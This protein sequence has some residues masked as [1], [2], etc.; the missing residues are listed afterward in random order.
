M[1]QLRIAGER[2]NQV[3]IVNVTAVA[4]I[5]FSLLGT[6]PLFYQLDEYRYNI[7]VRDPA[8]VLEVLFYSTVNIVFFLLGVIFIRKVVGLEDNKFSSSDIKPLSGFQYK[9]LYVVFIFCV[10]VLFKYLSQVDKIA[11]FVALTDVDSSIK[12]ARSDMGNS[13]S[14]KYH[15]YKLVMHDF[16]SLLTYC[17]FAL[18][19]MRKT[20]KS[21]LFFIITFIYSVFVDIMATEKAPLAWLLVGLFMV[22]FLVRRDGFVPFRKLISF[23]LLLVV[24]LMFSYIYFMGVRDFGSAIWSVFSRTFSGSIFPAYFYLEFF[25]EHQDYLFGKTFPN[26]GGLMPYEPYRY[27]I[28]VMNWLFPKLADSGVVG[29][30]PT[31]FWGEAYAN[32]GPIG[33]PIVAF[34]I[35][36]F[37]ALVSCLVSRLE[38]NPV[39]IGFLVWLILIFKSLST[40][41]FS[42]Y[43]Y[44]IY[45]VFVSVLVLFIYSM[46]G[47]INI[48]KK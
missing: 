36:C 43:L 30:A 32:F 39:S 16:G 41:G 4:L 9:S 37:V 46:R 35:G 20:L 34:I 27:T 8:V 26:P 31:V 14:G 5:M 38:I 22:Y 23:S 44:S 48:R 12:L 40:T 25:P 10:L 17:S 7:G 1:F 19:L 45:I 24:T 21:L 6:F 18:W 28:E 33:I 15:W 42:G 2:I 3:S 47:K 29:T 11:L 13:F